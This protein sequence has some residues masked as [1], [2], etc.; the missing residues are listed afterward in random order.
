[1]KVR[2]LPQ[3]KILRELKLDSRVIGKLRHKHN[4]P[5][6]HNNSYV[7]DRVIY[8]EMIEQGKATPKEV[9]KMS[10]YSLSSV[11]SWLKTFKENKGNMVTKSVVYKG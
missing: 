7:L 3:Y 8:C 5:L 9:S 6:K 11:Y 4:R 10:G 1:M 2:G